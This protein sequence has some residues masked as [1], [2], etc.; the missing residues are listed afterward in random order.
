[1]GLLMEPYYQDDLVTLFHGNFRD[2]ISAMLGADLILTDPPYGDTSLKW[3]R[4]PGGWAQEVLPLAPAMWMFGSMRM[5]L[6]FG[7]QIMPSW[8]FSQD[9][10]WEKHNGSGF[11]ND[12]F[13]RVHEHA[14][15]FYQGAWES[16]YKS[17]Q[18]TYDAVAKTVRRKSRPAHM[19]NIEAGSYTSVDGGPRL[20]TSVLQVRSEHGRAIH[21]T[22]KPLGIL[23][24]LIE[25]SCPPGGLV[26]DPFGGSGSTALIARMTGR[27][28]VT[29]EVDEQYA[30]AAALR[31]SQQ[32][33]D[34]EGIA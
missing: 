8:T 9:I 28:C 27:R 5:F 2:N 14:L 4:W 31:L 7:S 19:G 15:M 12:R 34:L 23:R 17:P 3:D 26:I 21:P 22:Q 16:I 25:Y 1:M 10:V 32:T 18:H 24:P 6:D 29:F 11:L 20:M 33:F 30:E 13:R